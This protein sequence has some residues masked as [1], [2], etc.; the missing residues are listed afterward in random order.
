MKDLI[1]MWF[2]ACYSF[3]QGRMGTLK[4][5]NNLPRSAQKA[6]CEAKRHPLERISLYS[7]LTMQILSERV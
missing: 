7:I 6:S 3:K 4:D 1:K 5:M 2:I